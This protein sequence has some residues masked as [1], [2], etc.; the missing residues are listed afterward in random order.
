MK[1]I[2][3]II[4]GLITLNLNLFSQWMPDVSLYKTSEKYSAYSVSIATSGDVVHVV[5][6]S[7]NS[8]LDAEIYYK[9]S[10]D[11]G[12][13]WS[14]DTRLTNAS[15]NLAKP[16]MS[17]SGQI[18]HVV[19]TDYRDRDNEIYYK[20]SS[21]GGITLGEDKRLTNSDG[22]SWYPSISVSGQDVHVVWE[23]TRDKGNKWIY[24]KRSTDGGV[25]WEADIRISS[26]DGTQH[27]S[28]SV[29]ASTVFV[30]WDDYRDKNHE[31]YY[32][33]STDDGSSWEED[34]RL[35]NNPLDQWNPSVFVSD[36]VVHVVWQDGRNFLSA[37]EIYYKG[38]TDG[39]ITWGADTRLT[40]DPEQS[41]DQSEDPSISV[42]GSNVHVV[43]KDN[44]DGHSGEIYYKNST[45][46][47]ITWG[48]DRV[49]SKNLPNYRSSGSRP[50]ISISGKIVHVAWVDYRDYKHGIYYRRNPTGNPF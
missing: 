12:L 49:L 30:V 26:V 48:A 5:W 9:R 25:T 18:I 24:Y 6:S 19:W 38:S 22:L 44:R 39:G 7:G 50:S 10:T 40:K 8:I 42:S 13:S 23:D 32:K 47:G 46:G 15:N 11:G 36:Q 28:V 37:A 34:K 21:D 4:F 27:P 31:I 43:W 45:D 1:T 29:S 33:R 41:G 35:T 16:I 3:L 2:I 20:S 17:V 14:S